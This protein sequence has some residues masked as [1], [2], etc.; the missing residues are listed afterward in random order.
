MYDAHIA[1]MK[2]KGYNTSEDAPLFINKQGNPMTVQ[3]YSSRVKNLFYE[4]FLP[5]L[6]KTCEFQGR[7]ADN[8]AFIE[9]YETEYPRDQMFRNWFTMYLLTQRNFIDIEIIALRGDASPKAI[10]DYINENADS[11][12]IFKNHS[13]GFMPSMID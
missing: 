1:L 11:I 4:G 6:K 2:S 9:L 3:T 8:A 10:N 12:E 7:Y 13:Y 5:A